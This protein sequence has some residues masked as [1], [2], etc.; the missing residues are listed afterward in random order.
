MQKG[1]ELL[2]KALDTEG[3]VVISGCMQGIKESNENSKEIRDKM[4]RDSKNEL[5]LLAFS[6]LQL[7]IVFL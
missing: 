6:L 2:V 4:E 7:S 5:F 1:H 3:E